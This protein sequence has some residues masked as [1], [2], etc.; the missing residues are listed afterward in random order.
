MHIVGKALVGAVEHVHVKWVEVHAPGR[1]SMLHLEVPSREA[2]PIP[3][4]PPTGPGV[5]A[6]DFE[7]LRVDD[8]LGSSADI[9]L[10]IDMIRVPVPL[11][12]W[13]RGGMAPSITGRI[14]ANEN[15]GQ[16][17]KRPPSLWPSWNRKGSVCT[18]RPKCATSGKNTLWRW[19]TQGESV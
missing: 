6:N 16:R 13:T 17:R 2:S 3:L 19:N 9:D 5:A 18:W 12:I 7:V 10:D 11:M 4:V 14:G 1:G 8:V 15:V